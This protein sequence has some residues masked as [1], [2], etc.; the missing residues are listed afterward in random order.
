MKLD[1]AARIYIKTIPFLGVTFLIAIL[2]CYIFP[3]ADLRVGTDP[4]Y[5]GAFGDFVGGILNPIFG[6]FTLFGLVIT[7]WLQKEILDVQKQELADT[8]AELKKSAEA[9]HVQNKTMLVQNFE[10]TFFQ[11]L[12]R[13]SELLEKVE[14]GYDLNSQCLKGLKAIDNILYKIRK[15]NDRYLIVYEK[16][17]KTIG[18][19]F[20]NLYHI[21]KFIENNE[22]ITEDLKISYASLARAQLSSSEV[23]LLF[24]NCQEK[25]GEGLKHYVIKYRL[26]KHIDESQLSNPDDIRDSKIYPMEAYR[27][28]D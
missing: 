27:A 9:L 23:S 16:E 3:R 20:R 1:Q 14:H 2:A 19:Y 7:V 21:F 28:R 10:G 24:Y 12:R 25:F 17:N 26:L 18:P 11:M 4:S 15:E 6:V 5:W 22:G 8:R 13:Q